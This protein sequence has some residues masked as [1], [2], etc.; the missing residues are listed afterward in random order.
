MPFRPNLKFACVGF[1][2]VLAGCKDQGNSS[3]L[4]IVQGSIKKHDPA[5]L[6]LGVDADRNQVCSGVAVSA[7]TALMAGHCVKDP[8]L[9]NG[10]SYKV[11]DKIYKSTRLYTWMALKN[12]DSL[13]EALAARDLAV[14]YFAERP[15]NAFKNLSRQS[16]TELQPV[17][18]VGYGVTD[19][20]PTQATRPQNPT[21]SHGN[22][23]IA[24]LSFDNEGLI[25][26]QATN[27]PAKQNNAIA[28]QGDSGGPL[29]NNTG[30]VI[31]I[32]AGLYFVKG[33]PASSP[34]SFQNQIPSKE[35][36]GW[37]TA[38]NVYANLASPAAI[39]LMQYAVNDL[40]EI[41]GFNKGQPTSFNQHDQAFMSESPDLS[42]V[43]RQRLEDKFIALCGGG[44][45][46]N[47]GAGNQNRNSNNAG[48]GQYDNYNRGNFGTGNANGQNNNS[49]QNGSP[50]SFQSTCVSCHS[51]GGQA[52][53][54]PSRITWQQWVQAGQTP[55][56]QMQALFNRLT[57]AQRDSI[58]QSM[59]N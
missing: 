2:V 6:Y 23:V 29:L 47:N 59:P 11:N 43:G 5:I 27:D 42:T 30:E 22:N 16:I 51:T 35:S 9:A 55:I 4:Q 37:Q 36:T 26:I 21:Q 8:T 14:V 50:V 12:R 31:G 34:T 1:L 45:N 28:G 10:V 54:N 44:S 3:D 13:S 56:P 17:N 7:S 46:Y 57:P 52:S 53:P 58:T 32:A 19:F 25:W 48:T 49:G 39:S 38:V 18:L 40:A 24:A 41:P 20:N 15:F 33:V